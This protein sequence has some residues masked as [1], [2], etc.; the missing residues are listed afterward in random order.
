MPSGRTPTTQRVIAQKLGV[1]ISTVSLA[2]RGS[3]R[4][5]VEMRAKVKAEAKRQG[6]VPDAV[7]GQLWARVRAG[8]QARFQGLFAMVFLEMERTVFSEYP[9]ANGWLVGAARR[10]RALGYLV[11][12]VLAREFNGDTEALVARLRARGVDGVLMPSS[13]FPC[14]PMARLKLLWEAFPCV[15]FGGSKPYGISSH[16]T[17]NDDYATAYEATAHAHQS[18]RKRIGLAM[19]WRND[20]TIENRT[21]GGY[22]SYCINHRLEPLPIFDFHSFAPEVFRDWLEKT[23]P[24]CIVASG[25]LVKE[26]VLKSGRRV[27]EDIA[28][29][30]LTV[31]NSPGWAGILQH[32]E[33]VGEAAAD[34][35]VGQVQRGERGVV[36]WPREVLIR[37]RWVDGATLPVVS[38]A[39]GGK[40]EESKSRGLTR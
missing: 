8:R 9:D 21:S 30:A 36:K 33:E 15:C 18:G 29:I 20:A 13:A 31:E 10:S 3:L 28:L 6:Y 26:L 16:Y 32:S 4:I 25:L 12:E 7:M 17:S 38:A 40:N 24:D 35:L 14:V 19:H 22:L 27:P 1:N 23:E 37:G 34:L 11:D 5:S 39:R 2:L